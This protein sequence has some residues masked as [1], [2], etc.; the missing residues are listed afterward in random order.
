MSKFKVGDRVRLVMFNGAVHESL[1]DFIGRVGIV[2]R[3]DDVTGPHILVTF[4]EFGELA[5][6]ES[7]L[8]PAD[9]DH[10]DLLKH[11]EGEMT[12]LLKSGAL[13]NFVRRAIHEWRNSVRESI[14]ENGD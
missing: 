7:E 8:E 12:K 3:V 4:A 10:T 9:N 6:Y 13:P 5:L 11:L 2:L 1:H 14:S